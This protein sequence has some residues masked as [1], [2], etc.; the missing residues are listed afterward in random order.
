MHFK[1]LIER[2]LFSGRLFSLLSPKMKIKVKDEEN[3][4]DTRN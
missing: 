3:E 2:L 4:V 1:L